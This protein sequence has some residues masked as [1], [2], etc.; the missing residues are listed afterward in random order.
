[1][2]FTNFLGVI[3]CRDVTIFLPVGDFCKHAV[4]VAFT[5]NNWVWLK[6]IQISGAFFQS[7][8]QSWSSQTGNCIFIGVSD[9]NGLVQ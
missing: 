4:A 1:M 6:E 8:T 5:H 9:M 3:C 2:S 7:Q